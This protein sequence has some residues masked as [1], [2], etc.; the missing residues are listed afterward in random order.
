MKI[1]IIGL[2]F[3]GGAI[4]RSFTE[5]KITIKTYDKC[6][7]IGSLEECIDSDIMF[8]CLP[9]QY[10]E[11]T[12]TYDL[13]PI[14]DTCLL[15]EQYKY[16]GAVVLK[17]TLVPTTTA[18][19]S[20]LYS[21]LKILHNPEFLTAKTAYEDFHQQK[22][23]VLGTTLHSNS[24]LVKQFYHTHYPDANISICTSDE[25]ESMKL[26]CNSFYSVKIQFFNELYMLCNKIDCDYDTV[27]E[28][29]LNNDWIHPMHTEVPGTDGKLSYGG[30][31]FPKDTNALLQFMK[32]QSSIH[33]VLEASIC[34]RNRMRTDNVNIQITQEHEKECAP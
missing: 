15:L 8:L 6:K 33:G 1:S 11:C 18:T 17:S 16:T 26:F 5:K 7:N 32:K 10:N 21:N 29:M 13:K 25:S 19:L 14:H 3:V 12:K 2:G 24:D 30:F 9:T 28:L 34:E 4:H 22:H 23:I 20:N 27:K 31:C